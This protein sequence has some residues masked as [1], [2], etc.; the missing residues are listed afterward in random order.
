[1]IMFACNVWWRN[2]R[3][4][5]V[6]LKDELPLVVKEEEPIIPLE[7]E[8]QLPK[9]QMYSC[10]QQT[11]AVMAEKIPDFGLNGNSKFCFHEPLNAPEVQSTCSSDVSFKLHSDLISDTRSKII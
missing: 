10:M 3:T 7:F 1:M 2:I 5:F 9:E 6:I 11:R 4:I 8:Q